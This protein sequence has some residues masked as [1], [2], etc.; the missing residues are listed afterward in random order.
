MARLAS[1][2]AASA[3]LCSTYLYAENKS[4]KLGTFNIDALV[5]T[6]TQTK[7]DLVSRFDA[8]HRSEIRDKGALKKFYDY[9]LSD[10]EYQ[11]FFTQ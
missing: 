10:K 5:E 2:I 4:I 3:L 8:R 7:Q 1:S 9:A 6:A 11:R